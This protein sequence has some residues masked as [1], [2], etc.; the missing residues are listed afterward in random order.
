[1]PELKYYRLLRGLEAVLAILYCI[2]V[3]AYLLLKISP[4]ALMDCFGYFTL[5]S[6]FS[7]ILSAFIIR[8]KAGGWT[9]LLFEGLIGV[10]IGFFILSGRVIPYPLFFTLAGIFCLVKA[11]FLFLMCRRLSEI[12][13]DIRNVLF[14]GVLGIPAGVMLVWH[15][16]KTAG[17]LFIMLGIYTL[18]WGFVFIRDISVAR[19][20]TGD[21]GDQ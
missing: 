11:F 10:V 1:M 17:G 8:L 18:I 21:T 12:I 7:L 3:T 15:P 14:L 9:L 5:I 16:V 13:G 19:K 20:T 4:M 6:G 2:P